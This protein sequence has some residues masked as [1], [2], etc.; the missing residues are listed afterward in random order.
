[1]PN[2]NLRSEGLTNKPDES[3]GSC[4]NPNIALEKLNQQIEVYGNRCNAQLIIKAFAFEDEGNNIFCDTKYYLV[5]TLD[6]QEVLYQLFPKRGF[7]SN[8]FRTMTA[9]G[10]FT[11]ST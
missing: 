9:A 1:M 7:G 11:V 8:P 6:G 5:E 3:I 2:Y 4:P 10:S